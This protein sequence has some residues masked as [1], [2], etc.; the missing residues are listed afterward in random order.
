LISL[1]RAALRDDLALTTFG[2][3]NAAS[4]P[5]RRVGAEVE[6]LPLDARTGRRCPIEC[7]GV[8]S[9]L[10]F[11]RRFGA[12]QG[13]REGSTAK[14]TPCFELPAP[15]GGAPIARRRG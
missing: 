13:W 3:G 10:P 8:T 5:G 14:G 11:L 12:S 4:G 6:F 9:T 7:E 15:V 1:T 2:A